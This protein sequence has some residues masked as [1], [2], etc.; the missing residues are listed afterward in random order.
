MPLDIEVNVD[1]PRRIIGSSKNI[2]LIAAIQLLADSSHHQFAEQWAAMMRKRLSEESLET[3]KLF[4]TLRLHGVELVEFVLKDRIFDDTEELVSSIK[5]CEEIEFIYTFLGEEVSMERISEVRRS[6]DDIIA[7]VEEKPI[8]TRGN[9]T[10]LSQLLCNTDSFRES[11]LKLIREMDCPELQSIID[12]C[13]EK[14]AA[15]I[16]EIKHKLLNTTPLEL[17]KEIVNRDFKKLYDFKEYY[18]IPSY[19]FS[20]HRIRF[21]N[22]EIQ[23]VIFDLNK[24]KTMVDELG[25]RISE[26]LKIISDRKRLEILKCL[27]GGT[28]YGKLLAEKMNLTTA[29]ISHHLEQLKSIG[30]VHEERLKNIKYFRANVEEVEKL[31]KETKNYLFND[32]SEGETRSS[33]NGKGRKHKQS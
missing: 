16:E 17:A 7:L 3:L 32:A 31:F 20:P 8:L 14:Y 22:T 27:I 29:T 10:G 24:G 30:L 5:H 23:L 11:I 28:S 26:V 21:Y 18:F 33:A 13:E 15:A 4:S 2:E 9:L 25:D 19:F 6:P 1:M 12:N